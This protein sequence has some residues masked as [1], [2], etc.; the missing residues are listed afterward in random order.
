MFRSVNPALSRR[1]VAVC[2][3]FLVACQDLAV[4]RFGEEHNF[5]KFYGGPGIEEGHDMVELADGGFALLGTS[6]SFTTNRNNSDVYLVRTDALG[7]AQWERTY[8]DSLH[9]EV[10]RGLATTPDD[11]W[12]VVGTRQVLGSEDSDLLLLRLDPAGEVVW[13]RTFGEAGSIEQ[14]NQ[15]QPTTDGGYIVIGDTRTPALA[16]TRGTDMF[17]LKVT[18][19]GDEEW[20]RIYGFQEGKNDTGV[21]VAEAPNGDFVWFGSN[22]IE[23]RNGQFEKMRVVRSN[24]LGNLR[25]DRFYGPDNE[26]ITAGKL[27][28]DTPGFILAGTRGRGA[29]AN[30]FVTKI[31]E[32]GNVL[33]EAT[34]EGPASEQATDIVPLAAGGY[35]VVGTSIALGISNSDILI[36]LIDREGRFTHT[37]TFGREEEGLEL[38]RA[39]V[40]TRDGGFALIGTISFETNRMMALHKV[41]SMAFRT[42]P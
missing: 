26:H 15:V 31:D 1:G 41:Q 21:S 42:L 30:M 27:R 5:I 2:F 23:E 4:E 35:A 39:L 19:N 34:L 7:N 37:A 13:Q 25:W 6:T 36:A 20:R 33:W 18:A 11:G 29:A 9:N 24:T 22:E 12:I 17:V 10:G 32:E 28:R 8:G 40:Q 16:N 38:G 14:G 3:L